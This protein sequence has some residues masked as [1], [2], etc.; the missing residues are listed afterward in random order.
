MNLV[1]KYSGAGLDAQSSSEE[2]HST[3]SVS[4]KP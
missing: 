1:P 4:I 2:H 3:A